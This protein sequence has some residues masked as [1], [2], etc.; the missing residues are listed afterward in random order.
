MTKEIAKAV[1]DGRIDGMSTREVAE[2]FG[3][4]QRKAL[5]ALTAIISGEC[6]EHPFEHSPSDE[7]VAIHDG[8]MFVRGNNGDFME[9]KRGFNHY[10]WFLT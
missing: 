6:T 10:T 2:M 8:R 9:G 4:T 5:R 7:G 1:W 3:C